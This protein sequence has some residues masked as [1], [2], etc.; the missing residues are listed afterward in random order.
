[1]ELIAPNDVSGERIAAAEHLAGGIQIAAA[2]GFA[3]PRAAD[4]LAAEGNRGQP[5]NG[6]TE[7]VAEPFEQLHVP[8]SLVS[9]AERAANA[10]AVNGAEV[11]HQ[12]ANELFA[13]NFADRLVETNQKR[14]VDS[15]R[16][17]HAQFLRQRI[18]QRRI[19]F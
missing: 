5:V 6:E 12:A 7:F 9:E 17:D 11:A 15:Q 19:A 18:N 2:N 16:F 4:H 3:N 14:G 10:E 13:G 8:A 1:A